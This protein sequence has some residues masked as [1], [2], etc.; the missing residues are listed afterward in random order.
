MQ[1]RN[2]S[3]NT[4]HNCCFRHYSPAENISPDANVNTSPLIGADHGPWRTWPSLWPHSLDIMRD[5]W[6]EPYSLRP[7]FTDVV[8]LLEN[9]IENDAVRTRWLLWF[10]CKLSL[11]ISCELT[12]LTVQISLKKRNKH[13]CPAKFNLF[14]QQLKGH[15]LV[16]EKTGVCSWK[17][18]C[19]YR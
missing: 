19:C 11:K 16:L 8:L 10:T 5:C 18:P 2:V 4:Q 9:I 6:L 3:E 14:N 15:S 12:F 17:Q 1:T 13:K 7:S